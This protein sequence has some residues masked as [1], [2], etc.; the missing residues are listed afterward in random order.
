MHENKFEDLT[1]PRYLR[2]KYMLENQIET[3]EDLIQF[4]TVFGLMRKKK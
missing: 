3:A 1:D 4:W 2:Y